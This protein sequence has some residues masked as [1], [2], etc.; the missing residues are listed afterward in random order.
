MTAYPNSPIFFWCFAAIQ[1]VRQVQQERTQVVCGN[2]EAQKR[3]TDSNCTPAIDLGLGN[4]HLAGIVVCACSRHEVQ[5][6]LLPF[7]IKVT[8]FVWE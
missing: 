2:K 1:L 3:L 7:S 4:S 8:G 6:S 5:F